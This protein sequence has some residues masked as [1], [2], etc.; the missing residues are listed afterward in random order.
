[1]IIALSS[2]WNAKRRE[3]GEALVDEALAL[4]FDALELGYNTTDEHVK[5]IK[6]RM[7]EGKIIVNSV[8]AY[9]PVPIGAPHGYPELHLLASPD[10]DER[11][12]AAIL[13]GK[14]R[15]FAESM[16]ARA[17]V[18]HAGRVFLDSFWGSLNSGR[19]E[20]VAEREG[21]TQAPKYQR[22]LARAKKRRTKRAAA[23]FEGFC[24]SLEKILPSFEKANLKLCLENLPSI[25][26]FP[27]EEEIQRLCDRFKGSPLRYW[28]DMGHGQVRSQMRWM[29]DHAEVAKHLLP[30]TGGIHIHDAAPL[31]V[32][33]LPPGD[34]YIPFPK[35]AFYA[36][37]E[38]I[39]VFE[40]APAVRAEAL[41]KGL[42]LVRKA[43]GEG[44]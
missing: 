4:G 39:K 21:S 16:G 34:G 11:V 20:A 2:N 10:E 7:A 18:L 23:L 38:I 1:M 27:D 6:R 5:G 26:G 44:K 12:L 28:H 43:W 3:S 13:L 40:P 32:D 24:A 30:I 37:D 29:G 8:H 41:R 36:S 15:D 22:M 25:E 35:F 17:V 14:T 19:L 31:M 42:Q 9:S 33:H